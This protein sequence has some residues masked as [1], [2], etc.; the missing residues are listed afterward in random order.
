M[1]ILITDYPVSLEA[2]YSLTISSVKGILPEAE[3][4]VAPYEDT[5]DWFEKYQDV[6]G[7]IT[8][9]LPLTA[10]FFQR[11]PG[12]RMVSISAA[13]Y[14]NVDLQAAAACHIQVAH[15]DEYCTQEVA[16]HC[17]SLMLALNR[18]LKHY[19]E[20]VEAGNWAYYSVPGGHPLSSQCLGIFGFGKI[21]RK[22][23]AYAKGFGMQVL[24]VDPWL[25]EEDASALGVEAVTATE[26]LRRA[27]IISNHMNLTLENTGFFNQERFA[28]MERHPIFLN[29]GRGASVDEEALLRALDTGLI[30]GAG[31][32]VLRH[33]NPE[34]SGHPLL[35]RKNV[36]LTPHAAFYSKDSIEQ[37][38]IISG[39]N[40]AYG[41][42]GEWNQVKKIV[43]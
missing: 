36:I 31:L 1:K 39:E 9:F 3:I 43:R 26:C 12:L 14:G 5:P 10:D 38:E 40:L 20:D 16:E 2:D 19:M 28:A 37:L 42:L 34:L 7:L 18:N 29:L 33:E 41:L 17:L 27:D 21:G 8:A 15:I 24:A 6:E 35:H 4:L 30:R 32:D 13:G 22:V 23:A 11:M 25:S